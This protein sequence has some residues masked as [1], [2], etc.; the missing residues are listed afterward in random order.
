MAFLVVLI[1]RLRSACT[2]LS[3]AGDSVLMKIGHFSRGFAMRIDSKE[4]GA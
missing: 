2:K 3:W 4:E 1:T